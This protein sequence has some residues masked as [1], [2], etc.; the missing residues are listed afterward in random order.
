M[1][2]STTFSELKDRK[3]EVQ[4]HERIDLDALH[5]YMSKSEETQVINAIKYAPL[6]KNVQ[7]DGDVFARTIGTLSVV[8]TLTEHPDFT[9]IVI[10]EIR[11]FSPP[12]SAE[13]ALHLA[14]LIATVRA[15]VGI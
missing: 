11:P 2:D 6:G 3:I 7:R 12:T 9:L 4:K 5:R 14:G 1:P 8:Y 15:A 10:Y 13:R